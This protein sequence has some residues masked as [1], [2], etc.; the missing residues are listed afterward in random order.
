LWRLPFGLSG[1]GKC[2]PLDAD[3]LASRAGGKEVENRM[4]DIHD[5]QPPEVLEAYWDRDQVN[6]LFADLEQG[7]EV[8]QV[9]VRTT[10][11]DHPLEDS[12]VTLQQARQLLDDSRTKAIQIYYEYDSK[13]WCDTLMVLPDT[14]HIVRTNVPQNRCP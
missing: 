11:G 8:R 5:P 7:A 13:T 4:T 6:A 9:Q 2:D 1:S 12:A 3:V 10:S 14:I